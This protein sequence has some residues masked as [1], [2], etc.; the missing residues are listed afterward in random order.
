MCIRDS[1]CTY[2]HVATGYSGNVFV[3]AGHW[4]YSAAYFFYVLMKRSRRGIFVGE[5]PGHYNQV[6][7]PLIRYKLPNTNLPFICAKSAHIYFE[8][9]TPDIPWSIDCFHETFT[10]DDLKKMIELYNQKY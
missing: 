1:H 4:T 9:V 3:I 7:S 10:L 5:P 8:D 6:Y 2:P